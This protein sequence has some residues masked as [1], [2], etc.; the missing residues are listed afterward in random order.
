MVTVGLARAV[1]LAGIIPNEN[2]HLCL[3]QM[4]PIVWMRH[5]QEMVGLGDYI[6]CSPSPV[7][8]RG[9]VRVACHVW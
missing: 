4:R 2:G 1:I 6:L 5:L 3:D 9:T 7:F 8:L